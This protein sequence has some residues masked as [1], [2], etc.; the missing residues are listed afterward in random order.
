MGLGALED[1]YSLNIGSPGQFA[2]ELR[3]SK[4]RYPYGTEA[5]VD[6]ESL[7]IRCRTQGWVTRAGRTTKGPSGRRCM[8]GCLHNT[9]RIAD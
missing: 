4:Y 9:T 8:P 3:L 6:L 1:P 5:G 7:G 2:C